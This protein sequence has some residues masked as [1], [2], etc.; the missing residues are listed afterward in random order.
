MTQPK[1]ALP[2]TPNMNHRPKNY[3]A[4]GVQRQRKGGIV[5]LL[6]VLLPILFVLAA[7]VINISYVQLARTELMVATDASARA[8]GR[9]M[10]HYQNVD[11]A[12]LAAQV[13]AALNNVAGQPLQISFDDSDNEIEFGDS[14]DSA[15]TDRYIFSKINTASVSSGSEIANAVRVTGK[16]SDGSLN[17]P[18][19]TLFPSM[20]LKSSFNLEQQAVAMQLDRDIAMILDRSG[21]MSWVTFDWP[22]GYDPWSSAAMDA[23]VDA[24]ILGISG[25]W[26]YGNYYTYYYYTS[27]NDQTSYY[28][29]VWEEHF[30]L[31]TAPR[32]PWDDLVDAVDTFL[33]VLET[34][35]QNEKVS[36]ATYSSWASLDL[37]LVSDYDLIRTELESVNPSGSTA[38]GYGL[39]TG[40]PSLLDNSFARPFA[41]KTIIVMTDGIHNYGTD[42]VTVAEDIVEDYNVTIHTVTFGS[43]ADQARMEEVAQIG[44][45]TH[46]HA[47]TGAELI[48]VFEEIANNLP[49]LITQ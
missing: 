16:V 31:G 30:E 29:W 38:I 17:G 23:A 26:Y 11:D 36:L 39:Q 14:E 47:E 5:I 8:G 24:G 15:A 20:G 27:G 18:L 12:K 7:F 49:T 6:A 28:Q 2:P 32:A 4:A 34:T 9:A 33:D 25:Y 1:L 43:G 40:L 48:E 46:Y 10:S 22:Y 44:G 13:T 37:N 3:F 45:G 19:Q 42:P 41:A 35:D 21:S